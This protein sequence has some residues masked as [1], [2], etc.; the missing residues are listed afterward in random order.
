MHTL[1]MEMIGNQQEGE[2]LKLHKRK[3][4]WNPNCNDLPAS[5]TTFTDELQEE[6][7]NAK[8]TKA[9]VGNNLS[10]CEKTA[11]RH[12]RQH[13]GIIIKP[14]DKVSGTCVITAQKYK[15]D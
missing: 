9:K 4:E 5:V 11:L 15:E 1:L 13:K 7:R 2:F 12:I 10:H 8:K 3:S 6:L 14:C